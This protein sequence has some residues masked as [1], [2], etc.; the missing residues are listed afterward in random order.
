MA[1]IGKLA[2]CLIFRGAEK[3]FSVMRTQKMWVQEL[4]HEVE[5]GQKINIENFSYRN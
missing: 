1:K 3:S 4:G 5:E 2:L